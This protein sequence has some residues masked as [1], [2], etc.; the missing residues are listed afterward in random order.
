[1]KIL[2]AVMF[3]FLVVVTVFSTAPSST[4]ADETF[5]LVGY[6]SGTWL[7]KG[8][9]TVDVRPTL[10]DVR[11][12][13]SVVVDAGPNY[14]YAK[15]E[16]G[17]NNAQGV[18]KQKST[19]STACYP[20][21]TAVSNDFQNCARGVLHTVKVKVEFFNNGV[22]KGSVTFTDKTITP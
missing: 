11:V 17:T 10:A 4:A 19:F 20:G 2:Q 22:S 5:G 15:Y 9:S 8:L 14:A 18:Y 21:T 7:D 1:M 3:L 6:G 16:I 13:M 12:E